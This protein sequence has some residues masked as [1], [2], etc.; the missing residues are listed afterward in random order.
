MLDKEDVRDFCGFISKL[1][2]EVGCGEA[3]E[4]AR[5]NVGHLKES[6]G[7]AKITGPCGD[8]M[9]I[10]LKISGGNITDARFWTDGCGSSI[11]CG[12]V[13]TELI[14]GKSI[15]EAEKIEYTTVLEALNGL[16]DSDVHCSVLASKT[17]KAAIE[18]CR[19]QKNFKRTHNAR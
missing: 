17:L 6:D 5:A 15:S 8:T 9:E 11:A 13:I 16:P 10:S 2:E 18:S 19:V 7:L 4:L 3:S 1:C 14:K 12:S